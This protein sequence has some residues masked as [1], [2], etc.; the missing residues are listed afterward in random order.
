MVSTQNLPLRSVHFRQHVSL[1]T[2]NNQVISPFALAIA[3]LSMPSAVIPFAINTKS[4]VISIFVFMAMLK[5]LF[6]IFGTLLHW[7]RKM[8]SS[9]KVD[10]LDQKTSHLST[11]EKVSGLVLRKWRNCAN[12]IETGVSGV[13]KL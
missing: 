4:F 8:N 13:R 9:T 6:L 2:D 1:N 10:P 11:F 3:Y 12:D 5:L 7:W